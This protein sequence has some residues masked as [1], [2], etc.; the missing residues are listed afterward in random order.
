MDNRYFITEVYTPAGCRTIEKAL[1]KYAERYEDHV[2][3]EGA[4][5]RLAEELR[6]EQD[7]LLA[8][9]PRLRPV[10]IHCNLTGDAY[11][12]RWFHAGQASIHF[13]L[14]KGEII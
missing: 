3:S 1:A 5:L 10:D 13:R 12:F 6:A 4:M 8:A 7:R 9:Q 2:L 11:G 14:I